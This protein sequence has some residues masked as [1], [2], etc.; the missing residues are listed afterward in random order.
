MYR[1]Q[2]KIYRSQNRIYTLTRDPL[3]SFIDES[4][5]YRF[6]NWFYGSDFERYKSVRLKQRLTWIHHKTSAEIVL[7]RS[8]NKICLRTKST[9][10]INY[11]T[12]SFQ[13][14]LGSVLYNS[15]MYIV[16][17][18]PW[19]VPFICKNSILRLYVTQLLFPQ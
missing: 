13:K 18:L 10:K 17:L 19:K 1:T 15:N 4:K 2:N 8:E 7:P 16:P 14:L 5:I 6:Q 3:L 11:M 12:T 9:K